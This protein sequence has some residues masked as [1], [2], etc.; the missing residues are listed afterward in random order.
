[1]LTT[2]AV[3]TQDQKLLLHMQ[4]QAFH[5]N[6]SETLATDTKATVSDEWREV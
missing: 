4:K 3:L 2:Y 6:R 1:M 5:Q